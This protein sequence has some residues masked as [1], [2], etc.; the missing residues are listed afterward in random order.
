[1]GFFVVKDMSYFTKDAM[2][3]LAKYHPSALNKV[4]AFLQ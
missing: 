2:A 3:V 1:L 4:E